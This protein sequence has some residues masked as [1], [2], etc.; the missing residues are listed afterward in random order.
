[1]P[2]SARPRLNVESSTGVTV[3]SFADSSLPA[4]EVIHEGGDELFGMVDEQGATTRMLDFRDVRNDVHAA[5]D[6]F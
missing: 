4:E 5:L 6:A 2:Q 3:V 1:M